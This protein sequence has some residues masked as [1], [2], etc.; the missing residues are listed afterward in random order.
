M[1]PPAVR[2]PGFA[3]V[4]AATV[5]ASVTGCS[6][7]AESPAEAPAATVLASSPNAPRAHVLALAIDPNGTT[8]IDMPGLSE[9]IKAGTSAAAGS[10]ELDPGDLGNSRGEVR[11][12]L[13]TLTTHTFDDADKNANQTKHARTWLETVVDGKVNESNR[14]ALLVIRGVHDLS[15]SDLTKVPAARGAAGDVR[16]VTA[17]VSGEIL[18]HGHKVSR[19]IPV[20]LTFH[21]PPDAAA[22]Q[23]LLAM[24][25]KTRAPLRL[26][27]KEHD[28]VP[29]DPVGAALQWTATLVSKVAETADVSVDLTARPSPSTRTAR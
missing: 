24:D 7:K 4:A 27:L 15:A 1:R 3:I 26:V 17:T 8:R 21:Y 6:K 19:E 13:T 2:S 11:I 5:F 23:P 25:I 28:I 16:V 10:L 12:D 14:W 9:H 29:R 20:E 18:L 22:E